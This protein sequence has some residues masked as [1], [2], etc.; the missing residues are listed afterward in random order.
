MAPGVCAAL[1][2]TVVGLLVAIPSMFGYNFLVGRIRALIVRLDHFGSE[3]SSILDRH[4]V[5][6]RA[7]GEELPSIATLRAPSM[8][9]F[10]GE[11]AESM[12]Q[13]V[14]ADAVSPAL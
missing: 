6:H 9:A 7:T 5:D 11:V 14:H 4:F 3:F 10:P 12:V 8:P 1:L 2:T 13:P